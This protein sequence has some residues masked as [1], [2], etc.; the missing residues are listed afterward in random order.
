MYV[1]PFS[2]P[3]KMTLSAAAKKIGIS[4][5]VLKDAMKELTID[6]SAETLS[7]K[8]VKSLE[9][10]FEEKS[11]PASKKTVKKES[12]PAVKKSSKPAQKSPAKASED[13]SEPQKTS[14]KKSV[15]KTPVPVKIKPEV[16]KKKP[17]P[18]I[19]LPP[20][21]EDPLLKEIIEAE[22]EHTKT[23]AVIEE[24]EREVERE[25]LRAQKKQKLT[26]TKVA[27]KEKTEEKEEEPVHLPK[28]SVTIPSVISV[29]EFAEKISVPVS[30]IIAELM[31]NG[32]IVTINH[33][34]DFD[35]AEI[36]ADS[37]SI[38]LNRQREDISSADL[39]QGNLEKM[40]ANEDK[41]KLES[42]PPIVSIMGHVD[43]GKTRLLDYIR[44]S[45]VLDTEA[46]GIT[47]KIGAYQVE[48]KHNRI[49]FLDTPG[50]EAFTAMRARGAKVTDIAILVVASDEGVKPQTRE[51]YDHI[52][53][54]NVPVIVAATKIDK[55]EANLEVLKGQLAEIGLVPEEWGGSTIVVPVSAVTGKGVDTLLD[56][57][58]LVTEMNPLKANPHRPAVGTVIE[59][60]LDP[61]FGPVATIL[62]NTGT[63][64]L[65]D[66]VVVGE[67]YGRIKVMIDHTLKKIKTA[68]P[69]MPVQIAG[70]SEVPAV[71]DILQVEKDLENAKKRAI[72]IKSLRT[73]AHLSSGGGL[74]D[75]IARIHAGQLKTLKIVL[76]ADT[77]GSLEAITA[78]I[79][80]IQSPEVEAKVIHS[81]VG[82]ITET[83]VLMASAGGGIVMGF[84]VSV[85]PQVEKAFQREKVEVRQYRVIYQLLEDI[86]KI[87]LGLL[88]PEIREIA[89]GD[90]EVL[91]VF[92]KDKK[93][94]IVG[95]RVTKGKAET[96][97]KV[98][99]IRQD[100]LLGE[101]DI[102]MLKRDK[103]VVSEVKEGY[104]CGVRYDGPVVIEVGDIMEFYKIEKVKKESL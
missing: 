44:K 97:A 35:T 83:D 1:F 65:M 30:K 24:V 18:D 41:S 61:K 26:S 98:R 14:S 60:N 40:L 20:L 63:L 56:M 11:Q 16:V 78:A 52:K 101:G 73:T 89:L 6:M 33:K 23:E 48:Y 93:G 68:F 62:I 57:I 37:F 13:I 86:K 7:A 55:P 99:I 54:A 95:G 31:K 8:D 25:I 100:K 10:Y 88:D 79:E 51:A 32:L 36:V 80:K 64:N 49:A 42:R 94:M 84:A 3:V 12:K 15:E 96:K 58:L 19:E 53:D 87:L 22:E 29:K 28:G 69:S 17:T 71:G 104:E 102:S 77:K 47:Q 39:L 74:G 46:G 50:H 2:I 59:S 75:I 67:S 4:Q 103:D 5:K 66:F 45:N 21:E 82:N 9:K 38:Q 76:K 72:E 85:P 27:E 70:L 90:L 34:I 92:L 81:S 91:A 43:H